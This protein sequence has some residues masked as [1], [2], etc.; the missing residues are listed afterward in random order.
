MLTG[1]LAVVPHSSGHSWYAPTDPRHYGPLVRYVKFRVAHAPWMLETFSP[2]PAVIDPD[3]HYGTCVTH[4]PRCMSVS[5]TSSILWSWWR[6]KRSRH[7][8]RMR[9]V[10]FY[11]SVKRPMMV[12]DIMIP[13]MHQVINSNCADS[14]VTIYQS[15]RF[16]TIECT[17][18]P[19]AW[20]VRNS[21]V[22]FLLSGSSSENDTSPYLC[23]FVNVQ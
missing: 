20:G 22:S 3:M 15:Y 10:Q 17:M 6:G 12:T 5:K 2:P 23:M 1:D 7:S 11:V 4:V 14:I 21:F 9:N 19:G 8:K 18:F 16:V 13:N